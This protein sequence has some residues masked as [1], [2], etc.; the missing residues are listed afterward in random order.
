MNISNKVNWR[1]SESGRDS[2]WSN[3]RAG[4]ALPGHAEPFPLAF[5]WR[6][7]CILA[8]VGQ[9]W[10]LGCIWR[11]PKGNWTHLHLLPGETWVLATRECWG[12]ERGLSVFPGAVGVGFPQ[13]AWN[14]VL[15]DY[16]QRR[17]P[18]S[19]ILVVAVHGVILC[20]WDRDPTVHK[21]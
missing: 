12:I 4:A 13:L 15:T 20:S 19:L 9:V 7:S 6:P 17:M 14:L 16:L 2:N 18:G 11:S 5:K 10:E 21:T 1:S 8:P 3:C